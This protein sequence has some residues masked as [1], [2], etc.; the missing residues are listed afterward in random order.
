MTGTSSIDGSQT[1]G[2]GEAVGISF[3]D[4]CCKEGN[5]DLLKSF[6]LY[7]GRRYSHHLPVTEGHFLGRHGEGGELVLGLLWPLFGG[8]VYPGTGEAQTALVCCQGSPALLEGTP[9]V[10]CGRLQRLLAVPPLRPT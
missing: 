5:R 3:I 7:L 4:D 6:C 9:H 8:R 2:Y 1:E 10:E